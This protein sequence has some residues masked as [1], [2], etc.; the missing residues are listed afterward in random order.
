VSPLTDNIYKDVSGYLSTPSDDGNYAL[1]VGTGGYTAAVSKAVFQAIT[2]IAGEITTQ[3]V[4]RY[5]PDTGEKPGPRQ[6]RRIRV[7]VTPNG[8]ELPNVTVRYRPGYY[9]FAPGENK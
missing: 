7:A 5:T 8:V 4:M 1:T 2:D 9:P 6:F 3:Y